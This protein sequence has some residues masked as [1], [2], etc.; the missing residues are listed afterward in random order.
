MLGYYIWGALNAPTRLDIGNMTFTRCNNT[1]QIRI[2][3]Q[4]TNLDLYMNQNIEYKVG[5]TT[6]NV[7]VGNGFAAI[8]FYDE[9]GNQALYNL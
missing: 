5:Y 4:Y 8:T 3:N 7:N 9:Y 2:G 1:L 6:V